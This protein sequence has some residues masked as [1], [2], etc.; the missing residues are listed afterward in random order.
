MTSNIQ[1][2][3]SVPFPRLFPGFSSSLGH[4]PKSLIWPKKTTVSISSLAPLLFLWVPAPFASG[5]LCLLC[6]CLEH[7]SPSGLL[8][9]ELQAF[10]VCGGL[11]SDPSDTQALIPGIWEGYLRGQ[12]GSA[13]VLDICN[14]PGLSLLHIVQCPPSHSLTFVL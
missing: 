5:P 12:R 13:D 11:S 6:F 3:P 2:D 8:V 9:M 10:N 4:W 7:P 14:P 1:P